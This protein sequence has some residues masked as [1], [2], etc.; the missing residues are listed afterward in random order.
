MVEVEKPGIGMGVREPEGMYRV[1]PL[2]QPDAFHDKPNARVYLEICVSVLGDEGFARS[3]PEAWVKQALAIDDAVKLAV[4]AHSLN[5]QDSETSIRKAL[6]PALF[7]MMGLEKAKAVIEQVI[8][9]TRMGLGRN[10][11]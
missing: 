2:A 9:V 4:T 1:H 7:A 8:R 6:L 5:P 10:V 11:S 3:D